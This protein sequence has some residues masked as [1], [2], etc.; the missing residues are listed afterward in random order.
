MVDLAIVFVNVYQRVRNYQELEDNFA[1]QENRQQAL[2]QEAMVMGQHG[3]L[4]F[5]NRIL[6]INK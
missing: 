2:A 3:C 6:E 4:V 1:S 5:F